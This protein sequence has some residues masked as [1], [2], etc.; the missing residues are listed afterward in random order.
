M[1]KNDL[2]QNQLKSRLHYDP[3]TGVFTWR[4]VAVFSRHQKTWNTKNAG[5]AAGTITFSGYWQITFNGVKYT[6][7]RLA[8]LYMEGVFPPEMVDHVN[9]IRHDN[10]WSNLRHAGVILN[11]TNRGPYPK[12]RKSRN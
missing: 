4:A 12:N 1:I 9:R 11:C 6:L 7:H 10:R 3:I 8:F 5:H 2:T